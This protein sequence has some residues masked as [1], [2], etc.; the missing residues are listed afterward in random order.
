MIYSEMCGEKVSSLGFGAMRL[1]MREDKSLDD[2]QINKM[3]DYAIENGV[4]YFDTAWPYHNGM[5]EIIIAESLRRYPREKYFLATK[6]PGHQIAETYY[7]EEIFTAQLKKCRV[8]YFDF[9]LLHNVYENSIETYMSPKWKILDYFVEQKE[10]GKIKHLGFSSHGRP[11]TLKRF[12]DYCG[13]KMEF[14]QIQL[15]Y[16]DW[17]LQDAEE[18]IKILHERNIPVIVMEPLRGGRLANLTQEEAAVLKQKRPEE[19]CASWSFRW[20]QKLSDVKVT[21]SGMSSLDQMIDNVKTYS[22]GNALSAEE[23]KILMNLAEG[24]K[25]AVPCTGCRYCVDSCPKKINIPFMMKLYNDI[26]FQPSFT[27][28]MQLDDIPLEKQPASCAAC[29]ACAKMCPQKIDIPSVMKDFTIR[30]EKIPKWADICRERA[31]ANKK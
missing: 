26:K 17:S 15:N 3:I 24:M 4:N 14:C 16:L 11:E 23:E 13:D 8:N 9:Y 12:L 7:P 1:P 18:K 21:L 29:G 25:N 2:V 30:L 20:L 6:Y 28:G 5:S 27:T 19:S 10:N 31:A 22:E